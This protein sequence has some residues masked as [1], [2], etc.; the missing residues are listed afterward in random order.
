MIQ[1]AIKKIEPIVTATTG[2]KNVKSSLNYNL[3]IDINKDAKFSI[4]VDP[5]TRDELQVQGLGQ[6]NAGVNPNGDISITGTYNLTDG[7]YQLN[8][9]FLKR[10]FALQQGSTIT[11]SGDPQNAEADITAIYE[12][13]VSPYDL[14]ANEVAEN[15][16]NTNLYKQKIPFQ[17]ILKIKGK[18]MKPTLEFDVQLKENTNGVNYDMATTI[19]NKLQQ[20]RNNPSE[21]N[22]EVFA[23]LVMG[24]FIGEQ[25][26]DFF[27]GGGDGLKADKIVKE[28]VS[29][30]LSDAV[31]QVAS[32]LIKGVDVD[33]NLRTVDDYTTSSQHTDLS[34][35]VSKKFIDDRLNVT[36]GKNFTVDGQDPVAKGQNNDNVQFLPDITTTYKLSKDGRYMLKAYQKSGYETIVD[37]YFIE[38]GVAFTIT[39]EF[40]KFKEIFKKKN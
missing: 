38:T 3:N 22:K 13:K 23:L 26:K 10:K 8:N 14:V 36:V 27:A 6:L 31:S 24:R 34:L 18:V 5:T 35:G 7:S 1:Y 16:D 20:M 32:D 4:I 33:I 17:V 37:G 12:I 2:S 29:K 19:D 25:S 40:N 9:K 39:M 21:M 28:S 15:P 11:L 30:F